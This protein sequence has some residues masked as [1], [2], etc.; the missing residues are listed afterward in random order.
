MQYSA[1]GLETAQGVLQEWVLLKG[2]VMIELKNATS[3][4]ETQP[5]FHHECPMQTPAC[6]LYRMLAGR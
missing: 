4:T 2:M 6:R 1:Q 5:I 3:E